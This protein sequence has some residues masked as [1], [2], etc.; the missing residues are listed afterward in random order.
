MSTVAPGPA[1]VSS[2]TPSPGSDRGPAEA[3]AHAATPRA[4]RGRVRPWP[5]SG[6]PGDAGDLAGLTSDDLV[7]GEAVALDLPSA[8]VGLRIASALLDVLAVGVA[9]VVLSIVLALATIRTDDALFQAGAIVA[10]V[11]GVIAFPTTVETLTRGR[12]VGKLVVGLRTVRDDAGPI[13]FQ[14]AFTRSLV[15]VVEIYAFLGGPA[16]LTSL[17]SPRGKRLGDHAAG[18]YVVRERLRLGLPLPPPMPPQLASWA[19]QADV[20]APPA[21]LMLAVRQFL[22]RAHSITP[23]ARTAI[24]VGLADQLT[25]HVAPVPPPGTPPEA[26]L[27]AVIATRRDRDLARLRREARLRDR[28]LHRRG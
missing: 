3:P 19:A 6:R 15:G 5:G 10:L 20:S 7:T 12:S 28:L 9:F 25:D 8:P 14:Q 24:G 27:C 11:L 16:F 22:A 13:S 17:L 1:P 2:P 4:R 18:T 23:E 26:F 21:A